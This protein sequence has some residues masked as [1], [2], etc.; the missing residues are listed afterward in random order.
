L[1]WPAAPTFPP[2]GTSAAELEEAVHI[3]NRLSFG[4]TPDAIR[5]VLSVGVDAWIAQQLEPQ[6]IDDGEMEAY[7]N[8]GIYIPDRHDGD[9][10][11]ITL[12]RMALSKRQLLEVMTQFWEN[13]F[14]TQINKT[15]L[16]REELLEN[17]RFREL[18]LGKFVDLL[19]ASAMNYPMTVYLDSASNVVGAPNENY[20]REILELH[21]F[22]VNNGYTQDDIVEAARCFTGWSVRNGASYFNPGQHDYGQKQLLGITIPAGGGFGDGLQ[23]IEHI[24]ASP[25]TAD[26][27]AWKLCQLFIADNP[28]ADV[29][30]AASAAFLASDGDIK[31]TLQTIFSHSRFRSDLT[32]RGNKTKTP[33]EF[34]VS[35]ARLLESVPVSNTLRNYLDRMGMVLFDYPEPTGFAEEGVAWMDTNSLLERWN[36]INELTT[37]REHP[38]T[39]SINFKRM[40]QRYQFSDAD[41]ILDFFEHLVTQGNHAPGTRAIMEDWLTDGNPAGFVLTDQ[42]LDEQVRQTLGLFLRLPE[43]NKQ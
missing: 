25:N 37:N 21:S 5:E 26:F 8:S 42:V 28:P 12:A 6:T 22:G 20:A 3:L 24:A 11:G 38:S 39:P 34:A 32:Y 2:P 43:F 31:Q 10:R 35:I 23:L 19:R 18:A 41:S 1:N 27:I 29:V 17:Q 36:M 14:N 40:A 7:L 16:P 13:H 15:R 30:A 4:P 33:L 9:L